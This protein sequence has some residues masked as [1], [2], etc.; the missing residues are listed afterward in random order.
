MTAQKNKTTRCVV[1][2]STVSGKVLTGWS[3]SVAV[4]LF[5]IDA[6]FGGQA[7]KL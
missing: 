2:A 5:R 1:E 6:A 3:D 7:I 4:E